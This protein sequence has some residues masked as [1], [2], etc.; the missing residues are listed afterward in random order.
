MPRRRVAVIRV[1]AVVFAVVAAGCTSAGDSQAV[2]H[3]EAP[4]PQLSPSARLADQIEVVLADRRAASRAGSCRRR[5]PGPLRLLRTVSDTGG[6]AGVRVCAIRRLGHRQVAVELRSVDGVASDLETYDVPTTASAAGL[7]ATLLHAEHRVAARA[8]D[9]R[10]IVPSGGVI[11]AR[12]SLGQAVYFTRDPS[13]GL[14]EATYVAANRLHYHYRRL[15]AYLDCDLEQDAYSEAAALKAASGC[16]RGHLA[17][18]LRAA[19][20]GALREPGLIAAVRADAQRSVSEESFLIAKVPSRDRHLPVLGAPNFVYIDGFGVTRPRTVSFGGD[21]GSLTIHVHW[22]T[23]GGPRA[24]GYGKAW[25]L[26]P[27]AKGMSDGSFQPDEVIAYNRGDCDGHYAYRDVQWFF[28]QLGEH[29][30]PHHRDYLCDP[31]FHR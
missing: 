21:E 26:R 14:A 13:I 15:R 30:R 25:L 6:A 31:T 20:L 4:A 27:H 10:A 17:N 19:F 24:I 8:V 29:F 23:W 7:P 12:A 5:F 22:A 2:R 9:Q 16:A 18:P 28:P 11:W 1:G 3:R